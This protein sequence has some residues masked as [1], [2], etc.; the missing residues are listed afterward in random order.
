MSGPNACL[1]AL[2]RG[3]KTALELAELTCDNS[4]SVARTMN[5]LIADGRAIRIDGCSGRGRKA[6]YALPSYA[7]G[8]A[9]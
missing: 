7:N 3:P 8:G 9:A 4:G 1:N 2:R 5:G 6:L